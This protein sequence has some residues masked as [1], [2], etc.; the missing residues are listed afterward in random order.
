MKKSTKKPEQAA[1]KQELRAN[2]DA[3]N[4][5]FWALGA[6]AVTF[7]TYIGVFQ[8]TLTNWDDEFYVTTNT[9]LRDLSW[10]G[11][12]AIFSTP[13]VS[14]YHPITVLSLALNYQMTGLNASSYLAT[15]VLLHLC[16]VLFVF[17]LAYEWSG[18]KVWNAVIIAT[19]FGIH[20]MHVESV[21]WVSERKDVLYAFFF[22]PAILLYIKY[23]RQPS[24]KLYVS[25]LL[26]FVLSMLSKPAAVVLP[27]LFFAIDYFYEKKISIKNLTEKIPFFALSFIIGI[28]TIKIQAVKA[29][30]SVEM[31]SIADRI[32]FACYTFIYY[33]IKLFLPFNMAAF[34]PFPDVTRSLPIYYYI[35]PFLVILFLIILFLQW[36]KGNRILTFGRLFY[37][38]NILLVVQLLSIGSAIVAERYTY[39]P[40]IGLLLGL[41]YLAELLEEKIPVVKK[42]M[43]PAIVLIGL[44]FSVLSYQQIATWRDSETLWTNVLQQYPDCSKAYVNRGV[45]YQMVKK[46]NEKALADY[47]KG[48]ET[49][50]GFAS[51]YE[52]RSIYLLTVA[53]Q[54]EKALADVEK[55]L[56]LAPQMPKAHLVYADALVANKEYEK[57]IAAYG[58]ALELKPD[59]IE[60][61]NNRGTAYF[62]YL[63]NPTAALQDFNQCVTLNPKSGLY[64]MNRA[65]CYFSLG[66]KAKAFENATQA[67]QLNYP[68]KQEFLDAV[69]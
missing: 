34:H 57:A 25:I 2:L 5:L 32:L 6:V 36:K 1:N 29:I 11:L 30:A 7:V 12:K 37:I 63:K 62:N 8:N 27:E 38:I 10:D 46:N 53:K 9:L 40:Y 61:L 13:V 39:I 49:G 22:L 59:Y 16:N 19:L 3:P 33:I 26:L 44:I 20:P 52:N 67:R 48:V 58:K 28:V 66:D 69:K 50:A 64:Y 15:N 51:A 42:I 31:Y 56:Q 43:L 65:N 14:N 45:Y 68:V 23:L 55:W 17:F 60:V 47:D 41:S 4:V 35:A 24:S 54:P 18:K 21:A